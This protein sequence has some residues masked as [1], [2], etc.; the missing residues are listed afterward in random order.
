MLIFQTLLE[1][2]LRGT[3]YSNHTEEKGQALSCRRWRSDCAC[4]KHDSSLFASAARICYLNIQT[5]SRLLSWS[6]EFTL[7]PEISKWKRHSQYDWFTINPVQCLSQA[8]WPP[9]LQKEQIST[10][11]RR[12]REVNSGSNIA[13]LVNKNKTKFLKLSVPSFLPKPHT[14]TATQWLTVPEKEL[15]EQQKGHNWLPPAGTKGSSSL[16]RPNGVARAPKPLQYLLALGCPGSN[17]FRDGQ[18]TT[19]GGIRTE[20]VAVQAG[21][22]EQPKWKNQSHRAAC[23]LANDCWGCLSSVIWCLVHPHLFD[24]ST[25]ASICGHRNSLKIFKAHMIPPL[26]QIEEYIQP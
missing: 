15:N 19:V 10:F 4:S 23:E 21:H 24:G 13:E 22:R 6:R 26:I 12:I 3:N 2:S 20:D 8:S 11:H 25:D 9:S 5:H 14:A 17:D 18:S 16:R 1:S 7:S